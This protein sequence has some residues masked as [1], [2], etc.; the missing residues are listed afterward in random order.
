MQLCKK[1]IRTFGKSLQSFPMFW[2]DSVPEE[3]E[4]YKYVNILM[5]TVMAPKKGGTDNTTF[6]K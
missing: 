2:W 5:A 3:H 4:E 6:I 1:L